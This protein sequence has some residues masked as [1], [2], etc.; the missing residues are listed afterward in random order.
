MTN[1]PPPPGS[2]DVVLLTKERLIEVFSKEN[3]NTGLEEG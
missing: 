2:E 3:K 1:K